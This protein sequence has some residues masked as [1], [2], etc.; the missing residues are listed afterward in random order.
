MGHRDKGKGK[1]EK[2]FLRGSGIWEEV[3]NLEKFELSLER[4][5]WFPQQEKEKQRCFM[6]GRKGSKDPA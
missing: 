3:L 1:Q 6:L 5:V 2:G 4:E